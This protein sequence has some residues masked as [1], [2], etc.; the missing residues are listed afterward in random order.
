MS[1]F[2]SAQAVFATNF[3]IG[4]VTVQITVI[5]WIILTIIASTLLLRTRYGNWIFAVGG[6]GCGSRAVGVPV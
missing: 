3:A 6:R 5:Y 2:S 4:P 1:G